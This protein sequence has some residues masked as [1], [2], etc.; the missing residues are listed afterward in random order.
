MSDD[1]VNAELGNA[2]AVKA[3]TGLP[4]VGLTLAGDGTWSSRFW[5]KT[6]P[7]I[8]TRNWCSHVRVVGERLV[9]SFN[10]ALVPKPQSR[11]SLSRTVSAWG[12]AA[13][14]DLARL[15]VG[16]IGAGSVGSIV[17]E[18]LARTGISRITLLDFDTL[19]TVNLDRT[20]H[21][22]E[23]DAI[24]HHSKV[25]CLAR[26][27]RQGATARDFL[28]NMIDFGISE[29][30]GYRA[31]LDCDV[32]F[33]CVDRPWGRSV[34]N[35]AAY[36]HLIPVIDGGIRVTTKNGRIHGADWRAHVAGPGHRCLACLGQFD[37]GLV[38]AERAG[39]LDDPR[40]IEGLPPDHPIRRNENVFA[41]GVGAAGLEVLQ[42]LSMILSP[43]GISSPGAQLYH[44][45]IGRLDVD[46]NTNCDESC[47]YP[48][49]AAIGDHS[50]M[51]V[52]GPHRV[53]ELARAERA[54]RR[55]LRRRFLDWLRQ[56]RQSFLQRSNRKTCTSTPEEL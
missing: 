47:P 36:A 52:T 38:E 6:Q 32:L 28:V 13:Q 18:A 15:H 16:V 33:S 4:F 51:T 41:F 7:H 43:S 26:G 22:T 30:N 2:A 48:L 49:L 25:E 1:D 14:A 24:A 8:Y 20:L 56:I 12:A 10:D 55:S 17:A 23:Y 3:A 21:A 19:R 45:N 46:E 54:S 44:F 34:L 31:A 40:Y 42:M 35:F 11:E 5:V 37:P 27:L 29:E 53:A 39:H 9:L 50:G